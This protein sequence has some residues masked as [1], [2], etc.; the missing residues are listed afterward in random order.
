[1]AAMPSEDEQPGLADLLNTEKPVQKW[2]EKFLEN[3]L[4]PSEFIK[5]FKRASP[6]LFNT[7]SACNDADLGKNHSQSRFSIAK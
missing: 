7:E 3:S 1:M 2:R 4:E 5:Y 6:F